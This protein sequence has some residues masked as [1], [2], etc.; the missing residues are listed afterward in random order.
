MCPRRTLHT[1]PRM[2]MKAS[3]KLT[4]VLNE[5]INDST[6]TEFLKENVNRPLTA[7]EFRKYMRLSYN[8]SFNN[9]SWSMFGWYEFDGEL[10]SEDTISKKELDQLKIIIEHG[11][12]VPYLMFFSLEYNDNVKYDD[13]KDVPVLRE[14]IVKKLDTEKFIPSHQVGEFF[15]TTTNSIVIKENIIRLI[16]DYP[17]T[18]DIETSLLSLLSVKEKLTE[19]V[20]DLFRF[21]SSAWKPHSFIYC[22]LLIDN[23]DN[24]IHEDNNVCEMIS[25]KGTTIY[26]PNTFTELTQLVDDFTLKAYFKNYNCNLID[27]Q[28]MFDYLLDNKFMKK[29]EKHQ[30]KFI[31]HYNLDKCKS[32]LSEN[33]N[34]KIDKI[35][36]DNFKVEEAVC[37]ILL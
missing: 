12:D 31:T 11:I 34:N 14:F 13:Y 22:H 1:Q 25:H 3:W 24:L 4:E 9:I 8:I 21:Y 17:D 36:L 26:V 32:L 18:Y 5:I 35:G 28:L 10:D 20:L 30:F 2:N 27:S 7:T 15:A 23:Y 29:I 19:D 6:P 37:H 33:Y 16:F